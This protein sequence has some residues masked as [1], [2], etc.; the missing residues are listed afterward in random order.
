LVS[1]PAIAGRSSFLIVAF[2]PRTTAPAL[3]DK[4]RLAT[5]PIPAD[6]QALVRAATGSTQIHVDS[7][8]GATPKPKP[9]ADAGRQPEDSRPESVVGP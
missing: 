9:A 1:T 7:I 8:T 3:A 6:P 5:G 4:K 2:L